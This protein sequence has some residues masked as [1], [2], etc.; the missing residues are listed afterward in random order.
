MRC[1]RPV[2]V[3]WRGEFQHATWGAFRGAFFAL[4]QNFGQKS[5]R[6]HFLEQVARPFQVAD[7][8]EFLGQFELARLQLLGLLD[9]SRPGTPPERAIELVDLKSGPLA[10]ARAAPSAGSIAWLR[11]GE[12]VNQAMPDAPGGAP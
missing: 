12:L 4:G 1:S 9:Q 6:P 7:L 3:T 8:A 5:S 2:P 10:A 11:K